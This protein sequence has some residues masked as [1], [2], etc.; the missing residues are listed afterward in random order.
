MDRA[1]LALDVARE[2]GFDL[3][4]IA[5]LAPPPAAERFEGWLAEGRHGSMEYLERNRERIV[6]PRSLLPEGHSILCVGLGHSRPA[7][8]LPDGARVARYAAGRDYHNVVGK[9]LEKLARRLAAEGFGGPWRKVVD[10]GPLL[11]RSHASRAGLGFESRAANLLHPEFG[12]WF[13]LGELLIEEDL[14]PTE[15]PVPGSC[16]TCRACLDA[17]P[18]GALFAPGRLHAPDCIS[19]QTIE[20][21]G[22]VPRE[23][24]ERLGDWAFGCDVC[25]EVCP[26]GAGTPDLAERFGAHP[27]LRDEGLVSW[28]T[29]GEDFSTRFRGSPLQRPRRAGLARNAAIVLGNRP[30]EEGRRALLRALSFDPSPLVREASSWSLGRAHGADRG[31]RAA[32]ERARGREEDGG[33]ALA[34]DRDLAQ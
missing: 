12:P 5:P 3:A 2:V 30:S 21:R 24:R 34:I 14:V 31:V 26:F 13:F 6:D 11:E 20:N 1:A 7:F 22:P 25:S 23:L 17:C 32:L 16:G 33:V 10:A 18:T 8:A 19:Y 4:G 15:A 27:A 9:R 29:V 28:L